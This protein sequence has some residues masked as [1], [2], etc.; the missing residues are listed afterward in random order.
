MMVKLNIPPSI[1]SGILNNCIKVHNFPLTT[2]QII[3]GL[4]VSIPP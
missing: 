4:G 2:N 1:L 3:K